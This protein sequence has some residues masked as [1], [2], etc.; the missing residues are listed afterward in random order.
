MKKQG[1]SVS[2]SRRQCSSETQ[3]TA[4]KLGE[5]DAS[6]E[7]AHADTRR[8]TSPTDSNQFP[9]IFSTSQQ[10]SIVTH[11]NSTS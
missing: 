3:Y 9:K 5:F 6:V 1:S 4:R 8:A 7:D 2:A 10:S 11:Q